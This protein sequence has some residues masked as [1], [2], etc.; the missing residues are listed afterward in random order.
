MKNQ[1]NILEKF[2]ESGRE[3]NFKR[4]QVIT[5]IDEDPEGAYFISAGHVKAISHSR[6]GEETILYLYGPGEVFPVTWLF[7][8]PIAA[9]VFVALDEV[10]IRLRSKPDFLDFVTTIPGALFPVV[11]QQLIPLERIY[12]LMRE[13]AQ[14]KIIHSLMTM[15]KR[16][17]EPSSNHMMINIHL[18]QQEVASTVRV[19]R[20]TAGR[21]LND[22]E[23]D[24]VIIQGR[25]HIRVFP[26]K[27]QKLIYD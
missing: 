27:L 16:F 21:V 8:S 24:G 3:L 6:N 11:C 23:K 13:T 9:V 5:A 10:K 4:R 20:E 14:D 15:T 26:D 1:P 7:D 17:G 19:S 12:N 2:F 22:L 18:T 25:R